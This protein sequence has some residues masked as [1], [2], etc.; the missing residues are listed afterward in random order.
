MASWHLPGEFLVLHVGRAPDALTGRC[1][2]S[3]QSRRDTQSLKYLGPGLGQTWQGIYFLSKTK[4]ADLQQRHSCWKSAQ[5][6][7][8]L[9]S[10]LQ[11]TMTSYNLAVLH[12]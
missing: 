3:S 11:V 8:V 2:V 5:C 9:S 12:L 1:E 6:T 4:M 7:C 10:L